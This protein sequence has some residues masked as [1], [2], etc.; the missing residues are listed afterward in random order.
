M[1]IDQRRIAIAFCAIGAFLHLY[2]P[3]AVLPMMAREYG[4]GAAV[5]SLIITAGTL[6]VAASADAQPGDLLAL[7]PWPPAP[8]DLRG[9]HRLCRRRMAAE[10]GQRR[11]RHLCL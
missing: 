1:A 9:D 6:A 11:V 5:A 4:V 10:R 2:A 3:Q 8:A 7:R